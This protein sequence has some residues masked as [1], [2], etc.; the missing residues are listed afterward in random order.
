MRLEPKN[1]PASVRQRLLDLARRKGEAFQYIAEQYAL[2]RYLYR[3]GA[4]PYSE[5]FVLK[6]AML[7]RLWYDK[8]HRRTR[9]ADLLGFGVADVPELERLFREVCEIQVHDGIRFDRDTVQGEDIREGMPY[10]GIRLRFAASLAGA[11]IPVQF[12][13]GFGD[14]VVPA[15]EEVEFPTLLDFPPP[16]LRVYPKYTVVAEKFEAM[17]RLGEQNSRMKDFYDLFVL[18]A[19]SEFSGEILQA[20]ISATFERRGT[21]LPAQFPKAITDMLS[22]TRTA[23]LWKAFVSRNRIEEDASTLDVAVQRIEQFLEPVLVATRA[24]G[25]YAEAWLPGGPWSGQT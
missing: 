17:I 3:L 23:S 7:F 9:D 21:P 24:G 18:S 19:V 8:P 4:S 16:R 20:A 25:R 15:P 10:Q 6:G 12:D 1:L 5:R 11:R 22:S 2:E 13:I 14:A